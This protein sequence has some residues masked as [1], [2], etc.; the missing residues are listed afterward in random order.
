MLPN[1]MQAWGLGRAYAEGVDTFH[2]VLSEENGQKRWALD[3]DELK[4]IVTP[5]TKVILVTNPN[6]PTGAVLSEEEMDIIVE[7][8]SKAGA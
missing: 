2:L 8:A 5:K 6:N 4:R 7:T 1:Y 3:V